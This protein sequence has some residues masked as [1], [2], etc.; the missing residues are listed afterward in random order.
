MN[1]LFWI[2]VGIFVQAYVGYPL[3]LYVVR[4]FRR[5]LP[6]NGKCDFLPSVTLVIS[7]YNEEAVI[8]EKLRNSLSLDY[9]KDKLRIVVVSDGS[10]DRTE[11]ITLEYAD[12]GIEIRAFEE[13][14]GKVA[15]L[16]RVI[17]TLE[18]DIVV[19]SDANSIYESDSIRRLVGRFSNPDIGC[20]CGRLWYRNPRRLAAGEGE[21]LYWGYEGWIKRLESSLGCLLGANGAIYAYRRPLF[22]RVDPLMFCDDVIPIRIAIEGYLTIYEPHAAC[23]EESADEGAERRRRGRHAS[24]GLRSM[25]ALIG[26]ALGAG[27]LLVAY[28]CLCHRLLRWC[29]ALALAGV[30]ISTP[31]LPAPWSGILLA[32]QALF[33]LMA[34]V[35]YSLNRIGLKVTLAYLPY[36]FVVIHLAGLSGLWALLRRSDRPYWEPRQ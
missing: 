2:S 22:R 16:N 17:P 32:G 26:E 6:A 27:R 24:F 12:R 19:M 21:R 25:I 1:I 20:V 28:Q 5:S 33:Y 18:S 4:I 8:G 31:S 3:S 23:S 34:L 7:A 15:C 30:L 36:Y 10:N 9:P 11:Q 14:Q 29:G 35:G 13:R